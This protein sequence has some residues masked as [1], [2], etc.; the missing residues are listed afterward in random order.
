[1]VRSQ[2]LHW[3]IIYLICSCFW[4]DRVIAN[5]YYPNFSR[6]SENKVDNERTPCG[7]NEVPYFRSIR[8]PILINNEDYDSF[9]YPLSSRSAAMISGRGFRP[10]KRFNQNTAMM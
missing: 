4:T 9:A 3:Q 1:M 8:S 7:T 2:L 6:L 10:G 5:L